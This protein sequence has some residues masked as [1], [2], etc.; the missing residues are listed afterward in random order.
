MANKKTQRSRAPKRGPR[1]Q[2][3]DAKYT[4]RSDSRSDAA[5]CKPDSEA[6]NDISWYSRNPNLLVAA[7]SFPFPYRPGSTIN[8]GQVN[9][10][11]PFPRNIVIPGVMSLNWIP[12]IGTSNTAT[13]PASVLGKEVYAKVRQVYSGSL[14]ADAPDFVMYLMALDS[15]FA[16]IAWLKRMYRVLNAWS[17]NNYAL[18]DVVL[19]AM[20]LCQADINE[21][22]SHRTELWQ[23][24]NELVLQS[25]KFTCPASMDIF[26]RHYWMSDNVYTDEASI[27][28]Q[29]YMFNLYGVFKYQNVTET[30]LPSLQMIKL[31]V[32]ST[33]TEKRRSVITVADLITF[34]RSLIEALVSWDD[35]YT[36]NG[37][38]M[39]AY[40]GSPMFVVDELPADQPFAPVYVPEVLMQIENSRAVPYGLQAMDLR[41]FSV[42]QNVLT[43]AVISNP[44]Y[45]TKRNYDQFQVRACE[46]FSFPPVISVRSD[47]PTVADSVI[48]SR[49]QATVTLVETTSPDPVQWS[50]SCASEVPL[51]WMV[52]T[53]VPTSTQI[54]YEGNA[55]SIP[56]IVE[57]TPG[58]F[59]ATESADLNPL[60]RVAALLTCEQFDW[61][62]FVFVSYGTAG[63]T[64]GAVGNVVAISV[65][66]DTHN[67]TTVTPTDLAN[68]HKVCM[69]S[70]FNSFSL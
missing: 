9:S 5:A 27:N 57:Q 63:S 67:I 42:Y 30:N 65:L 17:P 60:I 61:H 45:Q 33:S 50:V 41:G 19:G 22:R 70:E 56:T 39:R 37:Y 4:R 21:L 31:P 6:M 28:S 1:S 46:G 69:F 26:N 68:L 13:D 8:L 3:A 51:G 49:L 25:R 58:I 32:I 64:I 2:Q 24:I 23:G 40:Q 36:I 54:L 34:G 15:I 43:N 16:Y 52:L 55:E 53:S 47:S 48:A 62:P 29:F 59:A 14:D 44:T 18:P 11:T 10:A 20:W 12:S 66:G 38:L 7:G 35:A